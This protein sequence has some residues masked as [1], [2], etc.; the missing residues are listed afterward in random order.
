M[1]DTVA[2]DVRLR[3]RI[4]PYPTTRRQ[5][6]TLGSA[7]RVYFDVTDRTTGL[8]VDYAGA[9]ALA[10]L[11]NTEGSDSPGQPLDVIP[12]SSGT[13]AV[14]VVPMAPGTWT[15]VGS[16]ASPSAETD[17]IDFDV[18]DAAGLPQ[19]VPTEAFGALQMAGA[20]AGA[21]AAIPVA[22]SVATEAAREAGATA[23]TEAVQPLVQQ[24]EASA[25]D[26]ALSKGIALGAADISIAERQAAEAARALADQRAADAETARLD[27]IAKAEAA[28]AARRDAEAKAQAAE[29]A[30]AAAAGASSAAT[31]EADRAKA[32]ADRAAPEA[33]AAAQTVLSSKANT[34]SPVLTGQPTAP[35]RGRT[36]ADSAIATMEALKRALGMD[37]S[38]R[39]VGGATTN[40]TL[41]ADEAAYATFVFSGEMIGDRT[42][43]VPV[44][45]PRSY[46]LINNTTGAGALTFKALGG[47]G[48]ITVAR[49]TTDLAVCDG[50]NILRA[51]TDL[52]GAMAPN[53]SVA[54]TSQQPASAALVAGKIRVGAT[55]MEVTAG[56]SGAVTRYLSDEI[57]DSINVRKFGALGNDSA[58]ETAQIQAAFD[59]VKGFTSWGRARCEIVAPGGVYRFRGVT[60]DRAIG[61]RGHGRESAQFF[62]LGDATQPAFRFAI[63][64]SGYDYV[65]DGYPSPRVKLSQF[66][67]QGQSRDGEAGRG[68]A[69]GVYLDV[70]ETNPLYAGIYLDDVQIIRM[71]GNGIGNR[72]GASGSIGGQRVTVNDCYG[73]ALALN[74]LNDSV[75]LGSGFGGTRSRALSLSGVGQAIFLGSNFYSSLEDNIYLFDGPG[76]A[77]QIFFVG[78]SVDR[79][80]KHGLN[81][82][83]SNPLSTV[84]MIGCYFH[85]N[86]TGSPGIYSDI[87]IDRIAASETLY[88]TGGTWFDD[89]WTDNNA[90]RNPK[91]NIEHHPESVA[92]V[93][94]DGVTFARGGWQRA[95]VSN[96]KSRILLNRG[97]LI[98]RADGSLRFAVLPPTAPAG[99]AS[100]TIWMDPAVGNALKVAP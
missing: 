75:W 7:V 79:G 80:R 33:Q 18:A 45:Q 66:R 25:T 26:A 13:F 39:N 35:T 86:S 15:V 9:A 92:D 37:I 88:L 73:T 21:S 99:L 59:A 100:G 55:Q 40:I 2:A 23:G 82:Q 52:S 36:I 50:A 34:N 58:D 87:F 98:Q 20:A 47:G 93:V 5:R 67:I 43:L 76:A 30:R 1:S 31:T 3:A 14:D 32:Q 53:L 64:R 90:G 10:W 83:I 89:A 44:T 51:K 49:G 57:N 4:G 22:R 95:G 84:S 96:R 48:G 12:V 62:L 19:G 61:I 72:P 77:N 97:P 74:S 11:P 6:G 85:T 27:A 17:R 71:Q 91:F 70:A 81:Y 68:V 56:L 28:E 78:C 54:D 29:E 8:P 63:S 69:H 16:I 38:L 42:I 41:T 94:A 46:T 65:A 24:A 60:V